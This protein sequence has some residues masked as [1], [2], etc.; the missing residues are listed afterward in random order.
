M[1]RLRDRFQ[2]LARRFGPGRGQDDYLGLA[3]P[4]ACLVDE[5]LTAHPTLGTSWTEQ[6]LEAECYGTNDRAWRFWEQAELARDRDPEDQ[7]LFLTC[8]GLGFRGEPAGGINATQRFVHGA[9][10]SVLA[11]LRQ[12]PAMPA[13]LPAPAPAEPLVGADRLR[14]ASFAAAL[15]L[16]L[17]LTLG[18]FTLLARSGR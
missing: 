17:G 4:V 1:A 2:K 12:S 3:Y 8:Y 10:E 16:I 11:E 13:E 18:L 7:E 5:L 6:K 15:A 14:R 9:R